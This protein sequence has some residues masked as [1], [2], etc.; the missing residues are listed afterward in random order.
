MAAYASTQLRSRVAMG[1]GPDA[2]VTLRDQLA[3]DTVIDAAYAWLCARRKKYSHNND[4]WHLRWNWQRLKPQIQ[5][6]LRSGTYR[7]QE[8]PRI[9]GHGAVTELW[10]AQDALVLKALTL[11]LTEHLRPHLS[12]RCF[13]L[14][15]TGGLKGAVR[16]VAAQVPAHTF[17]FRTDVTGYYASMQHDQLY[18][19][20]ATYVQYPVILN[21]VRQYLQ[22][23]VSDGGDYAAIEQ[24]ISLVCPL[25]PLMEALYLKPVDDRMAALGCCYVRVYGRLGGL[26]PD[27]LE[28]PQGDHGGE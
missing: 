12:P 19:M 24:G 14:A 26:G 2:T 27:A 28:T 22:R 18:R 17:V 8:Q 9:R 16:A 21:L 4:V 7:F 25:S 6:Q 11:V 5:S 1:T 15:G 3:S 10:A 13:H 23:I 20:V